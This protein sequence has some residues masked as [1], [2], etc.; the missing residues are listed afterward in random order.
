MNDKVEKEAPA[1]ESASAEESGSA[2]ERARR[3]GWRPEEEFDD[4]MVN[5]PEKFLSAEEYLGKIEGNAPIMRE[6]N[7]ELDRKVGSL[8]TKLSSIET[9]LK[10]SNKRNEE[11]GTLVEQ[12]HESNIAVG[13][14]AYEKARKELDLQIKEAAAD[15]DDSAV[16]QLI[17]ERDEL[18]ASK[19]AEPTAKEKTPSQEATADDGVSP[20]VKKWVDDNQN[21]MADRVLGPVA[22]GLFT[23]FVASGMSEADALVDVEKEIKARYPEKFAN[24]RR[25]DP[26][27]VSG[28]GEPADGGGKKPTKKNFAS[29]PDEAKQTYEGLKRQFATKGK[30]YTEAQYAEDYYVE[31]Q[32]RQVG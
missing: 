32:Q 16:S 28:A 23:S 26:P 22:G 24:P 30:E 27:P 14:R 5:K 7:R 31:L 8:E 18:D 4:S 21:I 6:R 19:P 11:L 25:N 2:E 9:E 17:S 3:Q 12:L 10:T 20:T 29:L 15:G 13:K 1:D